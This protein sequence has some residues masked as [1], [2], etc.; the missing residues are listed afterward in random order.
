MRSNVISPG[1][2]AG[3]EGMERLARKE[4]KESSMKGVP[5]GR[6]GKVKELADAAVYLFAE[7]GDFV[8]GSVVVVD[9]GAWRTSAGNPGGGFKYPDFLLG[10]EEVS[11]VK[12]EKK[13]RREG[14]KL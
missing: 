9:G 8:N 2:V 10:G 13:Q 14:P 6:W 7:T 11:G 3:T 12:G 1:P 4:D 5:V